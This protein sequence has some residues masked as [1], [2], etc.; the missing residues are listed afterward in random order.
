LRAPQGAHGW[1][2]LVCSWSDDMF[3]RLLNSALW[4]TVM[5]LITFTAGAALILGYRG[6]FNLCT[7]RYPTGG[8]AVAVGA[9][10]AGASFLLARNGNDLMDR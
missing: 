1:V 6:M 5:A 8:V 3:D 10:L 2:R 9:L 4:L 7:G